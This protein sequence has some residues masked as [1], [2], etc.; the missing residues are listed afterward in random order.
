MTFLVKKISIYYNLSEISH[1][2]IR[3]YSGERVLQIF[4]IE[5]YTGKGEKTFKE[6]SSTLN[7]RTYQCSRL[8]GGTVRSAICS[9][10]FNIFIYVYCSKY[11]GLGRD[12][13]NLQ[14]H[15]QLNQIIVDSIR[16]ERLWLVDRLGLY[17]PEKDCCWL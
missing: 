8:N 1:K 5:K 10:I 7:S 2:I 16:S 17:S 4:G 12:L 3:S 9:G 15:L 13:G 14:I 11:L 6:I